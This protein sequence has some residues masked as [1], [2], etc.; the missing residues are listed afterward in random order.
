MKT[1]PQNTVKPMAPAEIV[2]EPFIS[3]YIKKESLKKL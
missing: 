1:A 3:L 2:N